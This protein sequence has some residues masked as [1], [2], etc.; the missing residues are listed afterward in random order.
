MVE[1]GLIQKIYGK[2]ETSRF[3]KDWNEASLKLNLLTHPGDL[4]ERKRRY[5]MRFFAD[6][7]AKIPE[8]LAIYVIENRDYLD[9]WTV[10]DGDLYETEGKVIEIENELLDRFS[11]LSFDFMVLP[12][13]N[14]KWQEIMPSSGRMLY[15]RGRN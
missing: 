4:W 11:D 2:I 12:K 8:V 5:A 6:K 13:K 14:K 10:V 3:Q 7:A 15:F 1:T 9:L